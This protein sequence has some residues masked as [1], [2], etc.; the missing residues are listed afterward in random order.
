MTETELVCIWLQKKRKKI[1]SVQM[2][3]KNKDT[4]TEGK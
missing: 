4:V 1:V 3:F 2:I